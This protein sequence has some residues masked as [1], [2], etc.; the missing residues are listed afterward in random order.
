M[1]Q[2]KESIHTQDELCIMSLSRAVSNFIHKMGKR[3]KGFI[4]EV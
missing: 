4:K 3:K 2:G 1:E